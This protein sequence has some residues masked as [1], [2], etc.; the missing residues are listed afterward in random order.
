VPNISITV[1]L[2]ALVLDMGVLIYF[3]NHITSSIQLRR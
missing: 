3:I 1:A 2:L